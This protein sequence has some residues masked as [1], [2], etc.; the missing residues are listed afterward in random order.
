MT[1]KFEKALTAITATLEAGPGVYR[2]EEL[3]QLLEENRSKWGLS[4]TLSS[5]KFANNLIERTSLKK[6]AIVSEYGE[7]SRYMWGN[8][9]PYLVALSLRAGSYLTHATAVFLHALNEQIP[10]QVYLNK[11][12]SQKPESKDHLKQES[13]DRVFGNKQRQSRYIFAYRNQ[14]IIIL[15]GKQ[16]KGLGVVTIQGPQKEVL[17]VTDI[18][19]TL[20]DITVRPTYG[21][22][23]Y[24]VIEAF[25]GARE[26]T[27][28]SEILETL[29]QLKYLYPYHQAI[30]FYMSRAGYPKAEVARLKESGLSYDFY[31]D[32]TIPKTQREYDKEWRLFFPKGL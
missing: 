25:K 11:E 31:L 9:S 19:R 23:V 1:T 2:L 3:K 22:G 21:G 12:Q 29:A 18:P 17:R 6:V 27:S 24:Q 4:H 26:R 8:P 20:I 15:S 13:L 32:Y 30:G 16:T 5:V 10:Q 14:K 28:A 7:L